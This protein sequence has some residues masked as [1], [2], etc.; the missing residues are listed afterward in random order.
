MN[1]QVTQ[2]HIDKGKPHSSCLCPV[3]LA[4]QEVYPNEK[5]SVGYSVVI[6]WPRERSVATLPREVTE[7][8]TTFDAIQQMEPFE[9]EFDPGW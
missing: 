3:A 2:S 5:I 7:R 6:N 4:I 9:F 8:I 1:I